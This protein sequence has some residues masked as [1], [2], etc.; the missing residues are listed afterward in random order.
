MHPEP[1]FLTGKTKDA[2]RRSPG[3][4]S[5][6]ERRACLRSAPPIPWD[7]Q[8]LTAD[9]APSRGLTG[10]SDCLAGVC[11]VAVGYPLDTVKVQQR[12]CLGLDCTPVLSSAHQLECS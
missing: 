5:W 4:S 12:P 7:G 10:S 11:G 3:G 6:E 9:R 8:A 1:Q 2:E